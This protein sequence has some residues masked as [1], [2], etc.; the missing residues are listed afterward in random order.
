MSGLRVMLVDDNPQDRLLISRAL[1]KEFPEVEVLDVADAAALAAALEKPDFDLVVTDY[2]LR[3]SDGLTV[4]LSVKG[5]APECPVIMVTATGSEEI[6]VEAMK[7]GLDDYVL[8][9]T[10]HR[11]RLPAAV[12][13]A[14]ERAAQ[15]RS[16]RYAQELA[17][18]SAAQLKAIFDSSLDS[19]VIIDADGIII[20]WNPQA[21]KVFGWSGAEVTG[22]VLSDT[23][24]PSRY[25]DAHHA[26]L[27]R[28]L[29]TGE[30]PVLSRRFETIAVCRNGM[31]FPVELTVTPVRM[32][33]TWLFSGVV[34]DLRERR[35]ADESLRKERDFSDTMIE[36][37]PGL[38][39]LFDGDGRF[40]RWNRNFEL[41]SGYSAEEIAGLGPLD[42]FAGDDRR[43]VAQRIGEVFAKG[44]SSVE[45]DFVA[46]D[47]TR[48]PYF[49]TGR[50]VVVEGKQC[51]VGMGLDIT[52]RR[53][54]EQ[55]FLQA[56]KMEAVGRLAGGIAHDFNNLL[57]VI[58]QSCELLLVN[59]AEDAPIR[60]DVV[61][62]RKAGNRAA[63]L[64]RQLLAFSRNQVLVPRVLD[65]NAVVADMDKLLRRLPGE[66][67]D[68]IATLAPGLDA[69]RADPGQVEQVIVNLAVN[70]RDAMPDG[71][72]LTIETHEVELNAAYAETH[73]GVTPGRYVLL[74]VSD[75]GT[76]MSRE[77]QARIFEPF[78][79]TKEGGKGTG[80]GLATVYGIVTQS[81][82]HVTV[83]SEVGHGTTFKI[84]LPRVSDVPEA[85]TK[86]ATPAASLK[87]S[88]TVL[89]VEDDEAIRR[90][91]SRVLE[92]LGYR[93]LA[94]A[95]GEEAL[96]LAERSA[97]AIDILVSDLVLRGMSGRELVA[98]LAR[99][100]PGL[101]VLFVSGYADDAV[102]HRGLVEPGA[103]FLQKPFALD[104]LARKVREV[105]D[106]P[107]H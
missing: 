16:V 106:A 54:L 29:A 22:R 19:L 97:F 100:R 86:A 55:Q 11:A 15:R 17:R 102:V 2:R 89:I 93:A 91:S 103:P 35:Q 81:G 37:L 72:K 107:G 92:N 101:R 80:L 98:T 38:F 31:E 71:G 30:G 7:A 39:Y 87:G 25:R 61:E 5:R 13:L 46:K 69:V 48:T 64:T 77:T 95:S 20:G 14:L 65:L 73:V 62:I 10:R 36:S 28:F 79:T 45:A 59:L 27:A 57:T 94:A 53:R 6:A 32:G 3:W 21:E 96:R 90:I 8:K 70:A 44:T 85:V 40:V 56:Q 42:F 82:G 58:A 33:T 18:S 78:F 9:S 66:D 76:G 43:V 105:L 4:L 104:S 24:V 12:R 60:E 1:K 41:A 52:A 84:Y 51:A 63:T 68:V 34:R 74:A 47:G 49:L 67:V 88:E 26:G 83:H 99:E 75:T 50:R 23:I